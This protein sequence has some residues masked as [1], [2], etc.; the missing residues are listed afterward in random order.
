MYNKIKN[1]R[2]NDIKNSIIKYMYL[3]N[4]NTQVTMLE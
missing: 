1:K 2:I 3:E 4:G